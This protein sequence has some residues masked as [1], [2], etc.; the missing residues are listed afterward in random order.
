MKRVLTLIL[1]ILLVVGTAT[2][3]SNSNKAESKA[4]GEFA[5]YTE[6]FGFTQGEMTY[7]FNFV[8]NQQSAYLAQMGL[9]TEKSLK[10][11]KY[12]ETE[13]FFDY[14]STQ[15][16]SYAESFL[17]FCEEA[18]ARGIELTEEDQTKIKA[19]LESL[20]TAATDN[21][22]KTVDEYLASVYG[23]G[24]TEAVYKSFTEKA[25]L[26]NKMYYELTNA[27]EFSEEDIQTYFNE[28]EA[29]FTTVD[30]MG[31]DFQ[32]N[33]ERE[34]TEADA[35]EAANNLAKVTSQAEFE[36]FVVNYIKEHST[37]EELAS[38]DEASFVASLVNST[39]LD[40]TGEPIKELI[41]LSANAEH[42]TY[43]LPDVENGVVSTYF[44]VNKPYVKKDASVNV[45]HI[46]LTTETYETE[47]KALAKAEEILKTWNEGDA[48]AETFGQLATDFTEDPGS[49]Q[50]GG[51]YEDVTAGQMVPEFDSW[52][53]DASRKVGDTG[54]V[55][56]SYG[57]HVMYFD[58]KGLEAWQN[59]IMNTLKA[60]AYQVDYA[61]F[62]EAYPKT[63][64]EKLMNAIED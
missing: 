53:F 48:T 6:N 47:E 31:F 61:K 37:E 8:V 54:I 25:A 38:F 60:E 26:A 24:I 29:K 18:K 51:L 19:E 64:N 1:A 41:T 46:L 49:A 22:F 12:T 4:S 16:V 52:I 17:V 35:T 21:S 50:A 14:F 40:A 43:V 59:E 58:G 63:V 3:C 9:D 56:T 39:T 7:L 57:Y 32:I 23:K 20:K 28:N 13:T 15:A 45:R 55:K 11:Q 34:I 2:A 27:Y 44:L 5:V 42:P 36:T 30:F 62:V 10:E 33:A